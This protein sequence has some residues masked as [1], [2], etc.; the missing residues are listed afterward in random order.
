MSATT[1]RTALVTGASTGIGQA[2]AKLLTARGYRVLGT[3]RKPEHIP[4]ER[5]LPG[6]E[7]LELDLGDP[8]SIV[9]CAEQAG[10][11]DVL[12]NNAGE[13]QIGALEDLPVASI[14]RIL[15]VNTVAPVQLTQELLPGMRARGYG[16]V[17]MVGSMLA[18]FPLPFRSTYVASKLAL[19]GFAT[20][21]RGELGPYG[22]W[23][24]TVE[25][26]NFATGFGERRTRVVPEG[27][28]Y[29]RSL[30]TLEAN[31]RDKENSG[32]PP[33]RMARTI[34]AAVEADRPRPLY[35]AGSNAPLVFTLKRL[36][37]RAVMERLVLGSYGIRD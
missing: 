17:V 12:V 19:R 3:S 13:S 26:G 6:V 23:F 16:R 22:V 33:E 20:A 11:V 36:L 29:T 1:Q 14:E 37:P 8:L 4:A 15:R 34:L 18:S 10:P 2:T 35:A 21:A 9:R 27:S 31:A 25:P 5:R 32:L 28:P 7:Y 24:T 30:R